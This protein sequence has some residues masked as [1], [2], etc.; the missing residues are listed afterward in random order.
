MYSAPYFYIH[1]WPS[2]VIHLDSVKIQNVEKC[3]FTWFSLV[4]TSDVETSFSW[5]KF[6]AK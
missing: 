3:C 2:S 1:H 5:S 6:F 4:S